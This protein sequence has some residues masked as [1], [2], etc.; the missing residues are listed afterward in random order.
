MHSADTPFEFRPLSITDMPLLHEWIN[1]PHVAEW[2]D[3]PVTLDDV[4]ADF[5]PCLADDSDTK[6]FIACVAGREIGFIQAYVAACSGD[7]WWPNETDV[8]VRGIDQFLADA[9]ALDQGLGSAM[10]RAFVTHLFADPAVTRIQTDPSPANA[11]AIRCY[12]KV[13]FRRVGVVVTPDGEALLMKCE[14][15]TLAE[16]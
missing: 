2:W 10:I 4:R 16:P 9:S 3:S 7:G 14:R 11:R 6:V 8:G 15:S 12:E 1:R 5:I 13:G